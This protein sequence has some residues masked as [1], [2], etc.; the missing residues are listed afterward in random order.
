MNAPQD[1]SPGEAGPSQAPPPPALLE[2]P[3]PVPPG[4]PGSPELA[5]FKVFVT[6]Q[7]LFLLASPL[8]GGFHYKL[9]SMLD[10]A[11][12]VLSIGVSALAFVVETRRARTLVFRVA[13]VVYVLG[14]LD[15]S[16][17][18]L[19]SGVLGWRGGIGPP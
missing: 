4:Y 2:A 13:A 8:A 16:A 15:M 1:P 12:F 11:L 9:W 3:P 17:N 14:V 19:L 5:R 18:I 7:V 10:T 6:I